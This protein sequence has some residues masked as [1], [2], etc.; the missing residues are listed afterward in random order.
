[1]GIAVTDYQNDGLPDLFFS[2]VCSTTADF[3]VRG[4][5]REDQILHKDWWFFANEVDFVFVDQAKEAALADH[6]FG[7]GAVFEDFNLD[8]RDDLAV[9]EKNVDF[10]CTRY[11]RGDLM[12]GSCY[13][14]KMESLLKSVPR[15]VC[16]IAPTVFR[17][18]SPTSSRPRTRQPAWFTE[19][20]YQRGR[21]TGLSECESAQYRRFDRR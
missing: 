12:G 15:R 19:R 8:G 2:N 17:P 10:P 7:W 5:L 20:F 18:W 11:L 6:E 3:L 9:S 4:D 21:H 1:M 14:R 13:R 16:V